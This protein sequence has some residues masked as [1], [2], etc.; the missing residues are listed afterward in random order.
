MR[1][2]NI[3]VSLEIPTPMGKPDKNGNIYTENAIINA[4]KNADNLP[5]IIYDE[6]ELPKLKGIATKVRYKDG[7]ILV[8]GYFRY[9]G[10]EEI[11]DIEDG[12]IVSMEIQGFG[13]SD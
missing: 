1:V 11:V 9:G 7:N 13:I 8:D 4:C 5:I 10:T 3:N 6:N 12:Q 2:E